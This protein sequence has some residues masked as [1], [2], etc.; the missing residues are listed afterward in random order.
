V[1]RVAAGIQL[2]VELPADLDEA[3]VAEAAAATRVGRAH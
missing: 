3:A 1:H 2:Y